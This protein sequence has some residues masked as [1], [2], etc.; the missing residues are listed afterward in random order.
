MKEEGKPDY[1][2]KSPDDE[3]QKLPHTKFKPQPRLE[4]ALSYWWWAR[5]ADVLTIT[6][7]V[8]KRRLLC[9]CPVTVVFVQW[10]S[11]SM[12]HAPGLAQNGH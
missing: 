9:F 11:A 5:K 4:P 7:R 3:L 8:A 6:P 12:I 2:E 1:P 10:Q